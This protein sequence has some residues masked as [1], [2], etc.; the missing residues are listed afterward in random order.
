MRIVLTDQQ[1]ADVNGA[2]DWTLYQRDDEGRVIGG[3]SR[4]FSLRDNR[5][6]AMLSRMSIRGLTVLEPACFEGHLTVALCAEGAKVTAFDARPAS[7]VKAFARCMA[8]GYYPKL[9]LHDARRIA[10][11]G[12]FD[13]LFHSGLFYHLQDPIGHLRSLVGVAPV[14]ILDTHTARP[15]EARDVVSGY[16]G[17]WH[18]EG[19]W[20]EPLSGIDEQSFWLTKQS[21]FRLFSDCGFCY[22]VLIDDE[23]DVGPRSCYLLRRA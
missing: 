13:L 19:G 1:L 16:E 17:Q 15:H 21:L 8:F 5:V 4:E 7:V 9:L 11:L 23:H 12:T 6:G 10:E 20:A 3:G 18:T 2:L 22:E 14:V